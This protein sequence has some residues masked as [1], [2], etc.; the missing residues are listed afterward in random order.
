MRSFTYAII[1]NDLFRHPPEMP[2]PDC[3]RYRLQ[4][5]QDEDDSDANDESDSELD[6]GDGIREGVLYS[7]LL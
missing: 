3:Y 1:H 2:S 7:E 6:S 4:I 5:V